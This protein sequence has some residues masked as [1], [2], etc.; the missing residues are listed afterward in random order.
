MGFKFAAI[1]LGALV[2]TAAQRSQHEEIWIN[3][4]GLTVAGSAVPSACDLQG[5]HKATVH[6]ISRQMNSHIHILKVGTGSHA[7]ET[8][9]DLWVTAHSKNYG[10]VW[11]VSSTPRNSQCAISATVRD[12]YEINPK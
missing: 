2:A 5:P 6:C 3:L 12:V 4:H 7:S 8:A 9:C 1:F 11:H 10:T